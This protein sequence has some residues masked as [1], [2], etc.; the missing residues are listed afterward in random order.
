MEK[1][2]FIWETSVKAENPDGQI[3]ALWRKIQVHLR[4]DN[5]E[6]A[7][8]LAEEVKK[9]CEN[10]PSMIDDRWYLDNLGL[11]EMKKKNY[12]KAIEL[13]SQVYTMN[14]GQREWIQPHAYI[15]TNLA[16]A[17]YLNGDLEKA[18]KEYEKI[19]TLTT[20]RLREGDLY[21]K[22]FYMLGKIHK[23]QGDTAKAIEYYEEFLDLWKNADEG[24]PELEDAKKRLAELE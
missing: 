14:G 16:S 7:Q 21:A 5:I 15:L 13:F 6:E 22:S 3:N 10:T 19:L 12:P 9:I 17:Y 1:A 24:L 23:E 4:R 18:K 2:E 20:G 8:T 11:I